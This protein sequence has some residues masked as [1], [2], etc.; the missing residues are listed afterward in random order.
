MAKQPGTIGHGPALPRKEGG[1]TGVG[2][3][4]T[5]LVLLGEIGR[6]QGLKGEVRLRSFTQDPEAIAGYGPLQDET[7]TLR[8]EIETL[9]GNASSL[10]A[11]LNGVTTREAAE[12]LT[13]TKLYVPRERLP[14][15][16][17]EEWYHSDLV[18]LAALDQT[19]A[20]LGTVTAI[21]NFGAGDIVEIAP[22]AG[23][24]T[25]LLPFNDATVPEV[26]VK[27][28]FLRVVPPEDVEE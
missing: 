27:G 5:D 13:G 11:R 20:R 14:E 25:L 22:A 24:E 8:V 21:H 7:G 9:R 1:E 28:S 23:G 15:A 19:G 16:G 6:A 3:L 12:A 17:E 4:P 10:V 18:G 26:D 2:P